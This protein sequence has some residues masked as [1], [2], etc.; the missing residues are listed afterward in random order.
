MSI[1]TRRG[2][3][4]MTD[5]LFG[6]RVP[7][8][9][10]RMAALGAIDELNARLGVVRVSEV[11]DELVECINGIQSRLVG[12][13]GVV[14]TD[15]CDHEKYTEKGYQGIE[16]DDVK[17]LDAI[18]HDLEVEKGHRFR[19]WARPGKSGELAGSFIDVART[20]CRRAELST[21]AIEDDGL[22]IARQ[23]LNRLSD[24]LWL[25]ARD[26]EKS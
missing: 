26:R 8:T 11:S 13:M 3:E 9:H 4:G 24:V 12:L 19:G 14:A 25:L 5:L 22:V 18:V 7:K 6:K 16:L 1:S 2:D 17:M 10:E 21:W 20:I 23:F 15:A